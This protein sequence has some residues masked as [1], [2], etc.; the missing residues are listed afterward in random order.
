MRLCDKQAVYDARQVTTR[1][2]LVADRNYRE[3]YLNDEGKF[4]EKWSITVLDPNHQKEWFKARLEPGKWVQNF[5]LSSFGITK[6]EEF[7][8]GSNILIP[9]DGNWKLQKL[10]PK[11]IHPRALYLEVEGVDL[12]YDDRYFSE[13]I[14]GPFHN[15]TEAK[16]VEPFIRKNHVDHEEGFGVIISYCSGEHIIKYKNN[17]KNKIISPEEF[18][19]KYPYVNLKNYSDYPQ[20]RKILDSLGS[21]LS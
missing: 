12:K 9:V 3:F 4:S 16:L 8:N 6:F 18:L 5:H 7:W 17:S 19:S 1:E 11:T 15:W 14:Y 20:V 2:D 10:D 13:D 21:I